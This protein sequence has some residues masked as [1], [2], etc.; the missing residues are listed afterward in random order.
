MGQGNMND[1]DELKL[2]VK[3]FRK[4][5]ARYK[6][7]RTFPFSRRIFP[8]NFVNEMVSV[9][10]MTLPSDLLFFLDYTYSSGSS[11]RVVTRPDSGEEDS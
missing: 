5:I 2:T 8:S 9:Q 3:G 7:S 11:D 4:L 6:S 10:P 1:C